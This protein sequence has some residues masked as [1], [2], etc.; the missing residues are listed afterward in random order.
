[1]LTLDEFK[2][3]YKQFIILQYQNKPN[4]LSEVSLF[5]EQIYKLYVLLYNIPDLFDI[6]KAVGVHLDRIGGIIGVSRLVP[7]IVPK[8]FFGFSGGAN[9]LGFG[10]NSFLR[11]FESA[12]TDY[13]LS[14]S[15]YRIILKLKRAKDKTSGYLYSDPEIGRIGIAESVIEVFGGKAFIYDTLSMSLTVYIDTDVDI[16]LI[17]AI[18]KLDLIPRPQGVELKYTYA[19]LGTGF[20]FRNNPNAKGYGI[21]PFAR[22]IVI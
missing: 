15:D 21:L 1:M 17:K 8:K 18:K 4:A 3:E 12:Y 9:S 7:Y 19:P 22:K 5:I 2:N 6:D 11:K 10:K 13:E 16:N 14:D 20:G